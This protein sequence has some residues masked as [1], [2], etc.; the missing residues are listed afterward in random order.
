MPVIFVDT[1]SLAFSLMEFITA[2]NVTSTLKMNIDYKFM[3]Q[4]LPL[5]YTLSGLTLSFI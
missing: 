5:V 1:T 3:S 2:L 4:L